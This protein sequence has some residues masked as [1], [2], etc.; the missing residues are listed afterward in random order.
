MLHHYSSKLWKKYVSLV[1]SVSLS[2]FSFGISSSRQYKI[3]VYHLASLRKT[4]MQTQSTEKKVLTLSIA[5]TCDK[6]YCN[7]VFNTTSQIYCNTCSNT[8]KVLPILLPI[9]QY[10]NTNNPD[11]Y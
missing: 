4:I 6:T 2:V 10:Y 3:L 5:N 7:T 11:R 8:V 1:T 9:S